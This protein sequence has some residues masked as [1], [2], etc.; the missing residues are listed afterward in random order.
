MNEKEVDKELQRREKEIDIIIE[1]IIELVNGLSTPK[2]EGSGANSIA[3][4]YNWLA[5]YYIRMLCVD[6]GKKQFDEAGKTTKR[7]ADV[8]KAA[9]AK[10][11][12]IRI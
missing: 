3:A 2:L 1:K 11:E 6:L 7:M 8:F 12:Q 9:Q 5:F 10:L 4:Y